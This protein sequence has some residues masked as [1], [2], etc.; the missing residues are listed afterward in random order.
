MI[1]IDSSVFIQAQRL[2]KSTEASALAALLA[3]GEAAVTGPV[4][5]EYIRGA[6]SAEE[7]DFLVGRILSIQYLEMDQQA[8]VIA[9]GVDNR[10]IRIGCKV[11]DMDIA[12]AAAAI[13]HDVPLYTLDGVF[14]RI[15]ELNLYEPPP[16]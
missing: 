16:G 8:W 14:A 12:I 6:R 3:S 11:S 9:G 5:Q 4:I 10:Y 2:P 13:R 7:F 1:L 15:P